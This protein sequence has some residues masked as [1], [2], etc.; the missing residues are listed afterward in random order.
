MFA[1]FDQEG[2]G[3]ESYNLSG[4]TATLVQQNQVS[5]QRRP[6]EK[7]RYD[8][9]VLDTTETALP[10]HGSGGGGGGGGGG[11]ARSSSSNNDGGNGGGHVAYF[12]TETG[13]PTVRIVQQWC[14][15]NTAHFIPQPA[16]PFLQVLFVYY[17]VL[18][19]PLFS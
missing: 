1:E 10:V 8:E 12:R 9:N 17:G 15:L 11:G 5:K 6:E 14:A 7:L 13:M 3:D 18:L 4:T 2:G 19:F 16:L